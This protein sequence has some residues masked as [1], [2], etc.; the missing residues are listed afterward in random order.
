MKTVVNLFFS[1]LIGAFVLTSCC[2]DSCEKEKKA[3]C[4]MSREAAAGDST[5]TCHKGDS[6]FSVGNC[7]KVCCG[8]AD[9]ASCAAKCA[10]EG[11]TS[12]MKA[13]YKTASDSTTCKKDSASC[14][15]EKKCCAHKAESK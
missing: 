7:A 3:C 12:C 10:K 2:G 4:S 6:T 5:A 15:K 8:A 9:S 11:K 13:C 14:K 1:F